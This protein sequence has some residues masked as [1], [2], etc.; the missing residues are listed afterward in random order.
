MHPVFFSITRLH[1][2]TRKVPK[3]V[4]T[5]NWSCLKH[6]NETRK[7]S[8]HRAR[9]KLRTESEAQ[10]HE[11]PELIRHGIDRILLEDLWANLL[12]K[13]SDGSILSHGRITSK[14]RR[15]FS[16]CTTHH[17]HVNQ[18]VSQPE[19]GPSTQRPTFKALISL[20]PAR[21]VVNLRTNDINFRQLH[22]KHS[23]NAG[24]NP[25]RGLILRKG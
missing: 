15:K 14:L 19:I 5:C 17:A 24:L 9:K 13:A 7:D 8:I 18:H 1:F 21:Q 6:V 10:I 4:L 3:H 25:R 2:P 23:A 16:L 20:K 12:R 11:M 22:H